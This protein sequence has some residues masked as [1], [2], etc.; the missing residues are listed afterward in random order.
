[1]MHGST[2]IKPESSVGIISVLCAD[3]RKAAMI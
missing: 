3:E 1:M 2:N